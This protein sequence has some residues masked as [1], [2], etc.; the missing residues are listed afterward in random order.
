MKYELALRELNLADAEQ[1]R[2]WRNAQMSVLRQSKSISKSQQRDYFLLNVIPAYDQIEPPLWLK[3]LISGEE[4]IGYG[5]IVHINWSN[6]RGEVS[7]LLAPEHEEAIG[8]KRKLFTFYLK[9]ISLFAFDTLGLN[10][11]WAETYSFRD[12]HIEILESNLFLEEGR[13]REHILME[14]GQFCDSV[15]HGL[16]LKHWLEQG[17]E[18]Q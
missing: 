7:F 10:R 16:T 18:W 2:L 15:I 12:S 8:A 5:G 17:Q 9:E 4:L 6:R 14:S 11:I 13:L 1:I 3:G